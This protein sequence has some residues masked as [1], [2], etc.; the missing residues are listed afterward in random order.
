MAPATMAVRGEWSQFE[1]GF[2]MTLRP[3]LELDPT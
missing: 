1:R 3:L 2:T